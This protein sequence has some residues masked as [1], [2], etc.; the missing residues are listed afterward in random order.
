VLI[1]SLITHVVWENYYEQIRSWLG[2]L[3]F[4]N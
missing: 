1:Y 2:R 4:Y 3:S